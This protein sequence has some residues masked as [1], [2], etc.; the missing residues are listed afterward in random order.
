FAALVNSTA[1]LGLLCDLAAAHLFSRWEDRQEVLAAGDEG[2]RAQ[3]VCRVLTGEL[4]LLQLQRKLQD[5]VQQRMNEAQKEY[6]LREQLRAIRKELGEEAHD[7]VEELRQRL[8]AADVPP[9]VYQQVRREIDR[10]AA[11][12]FGTPEGA[13]IRN[14]VD[15][16]LALPWQ[17]A[18][19]APVDLTAAA[20]VLAGGHYGLQQVK[21]RI[22][23]Y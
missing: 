17:D 12:P 3:I 10:L 18:S 8:A 13:L 15:W 22:I 14:Y 21:D 23:E 2:T 19:Q 6:Y 4:N 20:G 1:D 16:L 5:E 7:E 11:V 9:K